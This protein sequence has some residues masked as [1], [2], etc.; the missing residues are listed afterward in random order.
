MI[1]KWSK[2]GNNR[3]MNDLLSSDRKRNTTGSFEKKEVKTTLIRINPCVKCGCK[4][5]VATT[6]WPTTSLRVMHYIRC[7]ACG[8]TVAI[9]TAFHEEADKAW[10]AANPIDKKEAKSHK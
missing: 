8:F 6:G 10:N 3:R 2:Y 9:F 1:S 5:T 7:S 4:H